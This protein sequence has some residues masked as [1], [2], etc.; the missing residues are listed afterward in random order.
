MCCIKNQRGFYHGQQWIVQTWEQANKK[1]GLAT[2]KG[3]VYYSYAFRGLSVAKYRFSRCG[4][5]V[6]KPLL[7]IYFGYVS[8]QYLFY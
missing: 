7:E 6:F 2:R 5:N 8:T 4:K 3:L 1:L